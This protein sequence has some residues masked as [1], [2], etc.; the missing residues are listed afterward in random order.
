MIKKKIVN[1]FSIFEQ[2]FDNIENTKD[3]YDYEVF[4]FIL[5][6]FSL[7]LLC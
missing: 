6:C 5:I 7:P 3:Y 2:N 1:I 4:N